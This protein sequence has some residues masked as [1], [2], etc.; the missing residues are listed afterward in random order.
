LLPESFFV[1]YGDSYLTCDYRAIEV[2]FIHSGLAALMTV[3]H[4][5][6]LYDKSNVQY[7]GSRI[8]RYDKVQP[9][10]GMRHIDYGLGV[11]SRNVFA[12]LPFGEKSDLAT[13]Y[14]ELLQ[15]GDLAAYEV[16]ERFYEIGSAQGLRDT[17]EFL[18]AST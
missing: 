7:D 18:K 2:A 1:L 13:V 10:S 15:A 12:A 16:G 17:I 8:L 4:N 3:Y 14:Q 11:F 5:E 9:I 6:D